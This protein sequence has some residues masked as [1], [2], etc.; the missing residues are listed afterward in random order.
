M[1]FWA[2]SFNPR[3]PCTYD[4]QLLG[5][6][7]Q[8]KTSTIH[9]SLHA[10]N[11]VGTREALCERYSLREYWTVYCFLLHPSQLFATNNPLQI[12][13]VLLRRRGAF[14][15]Y[16]DFHNVFRLRKV[17]AHL[18]PV[19]RP[20]RTANYPF[21]TKNVCW[22][23]S[24]GYLQ[25]HDTIARTTRLPLTYHPAGQPRRLLATC[26]ALP[27]T[28]WNSLRCSEVNVCCCSIAFCKRLLRLAP[29]IEEYLAFLA[30]SSL[31]NVGMDS[32][33]IEVST[34][35]APVSLMWWS[36]AWILIG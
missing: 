27:R 11:K 22:T 4:R 24:I 26:F 3:N 29:S 33:I 14:F 7:G 15:G 10:P 25:A 30:W 34:E 12:L 2:S 36:P 31:G 6:S 19:G 28:I 16:S 32:V 13:N 17:F 21:V 9:L 18:L 1:S 8:R 20:A 5:G 23:C 35:W